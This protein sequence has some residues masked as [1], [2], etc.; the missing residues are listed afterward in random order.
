MR[1]TIYAP[2]FVQTDKR[3]VNGFLGGSC[4]Q[5]YR[6]ART[7]LSQKNTVT[8][9]C[10]NVGTSKSKEVLQGIK[11]VRIGRVQSGISVCADDFAAAIVESRPDKVIFFYISSSKPALLLEC[12]DKLEAS[13]GCETSFRFGSAADAA[14]LSSQEIG[15]IAVRKITLV[16]ESMRESFQKVMPDAQ[17]VVLENV[18]DR[19]RFRQY[20]AAY[21]KALRKKYT[22]PLN[23]YVVL[24]CGRLVESKNVQLLIDALCAIPRE[25]NILGLFVGDDT[26]ECMKG[27]RGY[28]GEL[29]VLSC[30][31]PARF[32]CLGMVDRRKM[33]QIYNLGD[34]F[35]LP[36]R[37]GVEGLSNALLEAQA[38]ALPLLVGDSPENR[39]LGSIPIQNLQEQIENLA[40]S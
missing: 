21:K 24:F 17:I 4:E 39:I 30:K 38:S 3:S 13:T 7:L 32:R 37:P 20:S 23:S 16:N 9:I 40:Q 15:M 33:P 12:L 36:S 18:A 31:N 34:V 2:Y 6:M 35:C 26:A 10:L 28:S 22:I 8:V 27:V 14:K 29:Q 11:I 25:K 1:Y 19:Q 5:A